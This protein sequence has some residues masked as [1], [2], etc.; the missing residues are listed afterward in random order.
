MIKEEH[1]NE[2]YTCYSLLTFTVKLFLF[3]EKNKKRFMN[4]YGVPN[5]DRIRLFACFEHYLMNGFC[6]NLLLMFYINIYCCEQIKINTIN[7]NI[8]HQHQ[9]ATKSIHYGSGSP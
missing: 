3:L 5:R 9:I 4:S 7:V 1:L 8:E 2:F 6:C